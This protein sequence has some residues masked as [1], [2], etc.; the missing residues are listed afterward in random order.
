M[1]GARDGVEYTEGRQMNSFRIIE[2]APARTPRKRKRRFSHK[3]RPIPIGKIIVFLVFFR[4]FRPHI[5]N[6]I[7]DLSLIHI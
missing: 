7:Y 1:S 4:V 5:L 6:A 3:H 2:L